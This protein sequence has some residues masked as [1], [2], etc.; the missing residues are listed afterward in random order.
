MNDLGKV[1]RV[2]PARSKSLVIGQAEK[3]YDLNEQIDQDQQSHVAKVCVEEFLFFIDGQKAFIEPSKIC[4]LSKKHLI[5]GKLVGGSIL[6]EDNP[7]TL[8]VIGDYQIHQA[9]Q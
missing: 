5:V 9:G 7:A 6:I 3:K 4:I 2:S 8:Q 1:R